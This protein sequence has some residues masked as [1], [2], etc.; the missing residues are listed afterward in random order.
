MG[1][2][3]NPEGMAKAQLLFHETNVRGDENRQTSV[4]GV[5]FA[6]FIDLVNGSISYSENHKPVIFQG[7]V[8]F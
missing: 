5:L 7:N 3:Q 2:A 4:K 1:L 8:T 6:H